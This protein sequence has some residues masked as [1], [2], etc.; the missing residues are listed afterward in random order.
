MYGDTK[1]WGC[2][3]SYDTGKSL[4]RANRLS[5]DFLLSSVS[6]TVRQASTIVA[7]AITTK[8]SRKN[9]IN[10]RVLHPPPIARKEFGLV[11]EFQNS[12][13]LVCLPQNAIFVN[14]TVTSQPEA[15]KHV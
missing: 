12:H 13:V 5:S 9:I 14:K 2:Q 10:H 4:K 7:E 15:T 1:N 6:V 3:I 8:K 11:G